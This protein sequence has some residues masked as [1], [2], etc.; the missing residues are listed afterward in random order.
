MTISR[1]SKN[2]NYGQKTVSKRVSRE[3]QREDKA[4]PKAVPERKPGTYQESGE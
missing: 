3:E 4:V 1:A 2:K